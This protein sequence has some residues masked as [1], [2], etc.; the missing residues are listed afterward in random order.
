MCFFSL[1]QAD[2]M[3]RTQS[4]SRDLHEPASA[5]SS[6]G[7]GATR[8]WKRTFALALLVNHALPPLPAP[9]GASS[10]AGVSAEESDRRRAFIDTH[11]SLIDYH[12]N[13]LCHDV[14][15]CLRT[16]F[17][18]QCRVKKKKLKSYIFLSLFT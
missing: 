8:T 13:V 10:D 11:Y 2:G 3:K 17:H 12:L 18:R 4:F 15:S 5:P 9:Q 1:C 14:V 6:P 16:S 7:N